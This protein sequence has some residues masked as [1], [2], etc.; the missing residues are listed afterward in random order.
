[1]NVCLFCIKQIIHHVPD[2]RGEL[3]AMLPQLISTQ[4]DLD[5]FTPPDLPPDEGPID[6][7]QSRD[8]IFLSFYLK[9]PNQ[10]VAEQELAHLDESLRSYVQAR[11]PFAEIAGYLSSAP[12]RMELELILK[13]NNPDRYFAV[14]HSGAVYEL[15]GDE[16]L[17]E[18]ADPFS[19]LFGSG[20]LHKLTALEA[21][22]VLNSRNCQPI[23]SSRGN[24]GSRMPFTRVS[25]LS[26]ATS[27]PNPEPTARKWR[28]WHR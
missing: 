14:Y 3:A 9:T 22:R 15:G 6:I 2:P 13:D 10:I 19:S 25:E 27:P 23:W 24:I 4:Q 7:K 18:L 12:I 26:Q 16:P 8:D 17:S 11:H 28:F 5:L 21:R 1:M 20:G